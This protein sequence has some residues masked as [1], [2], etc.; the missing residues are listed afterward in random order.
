VLGYKAGRTVAELASL[1][2]ARSD[3]GTA[4]GRTDGRSD[5][6]LSSAQLGLAW[7]DSHNLA[8]PKTAPEA[9]KCQITI[10]FLKKNM[11]YNFFQKNEKFKILKVPAIIWP[12][13]RRPP[14]HPNAR[15][16]YD[17]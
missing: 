15:L 12:A 17:S 5:E 10:R 16:Q 9:P 4:V 1:A 11:F 2:L 8:C 7:L 13:Q 14:T 6:R 3:G